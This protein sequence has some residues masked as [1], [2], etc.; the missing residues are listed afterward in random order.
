MSLVHL[1]AVRILTA[2][3][4]LL[5]AFIGAEA[6]AQFPKSG[7]IQLHGVNSILTTL[8]ENALPVSVR[9][10]PDGRHYAYAVVRGKQLAMVIDGKQGPWFSDVD[11]AVFSSDNRHSCYRAKNLGKWCAITD[12]I[13][14]KYADDMDTPVF[15]PRGGHI[16]YAVNIATKFYM[17]LDGQLTGPY[18]WAGLPSFSSD[19]SRFA[20]YIR[21]GK[22][23]SAMVDGKQIGDFTLVS[24]RPVVWSPSGRRY[25]FSTTHGNKW[26]VVVDGRTTNEMD[27][28]TSVAFSAQDSIAYA[29]LSGDNWELY[30]DGRV[31]GTCRE[32]KDFPLVFLPDGHS[33]GYGKS[34]RSRE[35]MVVE[36]DSEYGPYQGVV[37]SSFVWSP[38]LR[39]IVY[40]AKTQNGFAVFSRG[41]QMSSFFQYAVAPGIIADSSERSLAVKFNNGAR[42]LSKEEVEGRLRSG[43]HVANN[44][45]GIQLEGGTDVYWINQV[46][47]YESRPGSQVLS[48]TYQS[49]N[50]LFD[51]IIDGRTVIRTTY[52]LLTE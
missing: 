44:G 4:F 27:N 12:S 23:L 7:A 49:S 51:V 17:S 34:T 19:G 39:A 1:P 45:Q 5:S 29:L 26:L 42:V 13:Q 21:M 43:E 28:A 2:L 37:E 20:Y 35:C 14:G 38:Y 3:L 32:L 9:V 11:F 33:L 46:E 50:E 18:D 16:A 8:P 40:T 41:K 47:F 30:L 36:G 15:S 6:R 10:S 31:V 52:K 22:R 25:A 24:N 48:M